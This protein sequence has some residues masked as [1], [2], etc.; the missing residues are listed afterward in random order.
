MGS[1]GMSGIFGIVGPTILQPLL[2]L[3]PGL[4]VA[5]GLCIFLAALAL[6]IAGLKAFLERGSRGKG[7]QDPTPRS[8][9][10][11]LWQELN[12]VKSRSEER[13]VGKECRS[14]WS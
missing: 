2:G 11:Q 9:D 14:R 13:R 6:I 8:S 4:R 3:P 10:F 12:R 1:V 7:T 5:L